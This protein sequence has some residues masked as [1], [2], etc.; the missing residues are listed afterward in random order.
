MS[1]TVLKAEK[2]SVEGRKVKVLRNKGILPGNVFGKKVKSL[3]VQ[4][5]LKDFQ[6]TYKEVGETGLLTLSIGTDERPVLIHNLQLHP[7]SDEPVHIDFLQVDL[8]VK[9]EADIPV[10][11]SGESPAEKQ[12]VGTVVQY[13]NEVKVE[14]LPADLPEK[15]EVDTSGLAEVDQAIMVKDLSYDKAKVEVKTSPD[16]IVAKVEPPQKEEVVEAPVAPTEG[17]VPAEGAVEAG[18]GEQPVAGAA[19]PKEEP[20]G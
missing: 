10:E 14:A 20:Q 11:L 3:A 12:G 6:K 18:T 17:E 19:E 7:I 5:D 8:K 1:K 13:V 16:E 15:F 4:V 9:V 2:R